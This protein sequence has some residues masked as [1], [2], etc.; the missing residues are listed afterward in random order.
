MAGTKEGTETKHVALAPR[1]VFIYAALVSVSTR[2][3]SMSA[4]TLEEGEHGRL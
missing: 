1:S 2:D 4:K 3:D